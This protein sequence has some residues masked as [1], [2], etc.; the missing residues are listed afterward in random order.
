M[1]LLIDLRFY[2]P[3]NYG[4][5][6]YISELF[7]YFIP[8]LENSKFTKITILID[9]TNQSLDLSKYLSWWSQI[10]QSSKF[11]IFYTDIKYYTLKEQFLLPK[12][13]DK[14]NPDL[15]FFFTF[16]FPVFFKGSFVYQVFDFNHVKTSKESS[17]IYKIKTQIALKIIKRGLLKARKRL[18]LGSETPLDGEKYLGLNL[19][20][21]NEPNYLENQIVWGGVKE[22]YTKQSL[23]NP[24]R[25]FYT[26]TIV[27][28]DSHSNL[29]AIKT[30][31]KLKITKPY[32]LFVSVWKKHKNLES[33]LK[34]FEIFNKNNKYQLLIAGKKDP[35]NLKIF[36]LL[37]SLEQYKNG[38]ILMA[39]NLPDE[40]IIYLQDFAKAF[41]MP[42]FAEGMGLTLIE[43][44]IRG[45]PVICSNI[46]VFKDFMKENVWYFDPYKVDDIVKTLKTFEVE[47]EQKIQQKIKNAFSNSLNY[48]WTQ[49]SEIILKTL[50]TA[51]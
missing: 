41:I 51:I 9:K 50:E 36:D 8:E 35:K 17:F 33:L 21:K 46:K 27:Q 18:F 43:S 49:T 31:E 47:E 29:K 5:A 42:S 22:I 25:E 20:Q 19:T 48:S 39:E 28:Y 26:K 16:N 11:S 14:I 44:A 37:E 4:L 15:T 13:I 38:N 32:F 1:H 30:K 45:T 2:R 6:I 34:S 10:T 12:I 3:E 7:R 24:Q 23:S 40:E